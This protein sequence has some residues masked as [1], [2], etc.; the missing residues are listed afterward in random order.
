[1]KLWGILMKSK[2]LVNKSFVLLLIRPVSTINSRA[3][4]YRLGLNFVFTWKR[5][6][7]RRICSTFNESNFTHF[8]INYGMAL[9]VG[10]RLFARDLWGKKL[11]ADAKLKRGTSSK[12]RF[13]STLIKKLQQASRESI[14]RT[15]VVGNFLL[16]AN[17]EIKKS[18][19]FSALGDFQRRK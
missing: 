3:A 18:V 16:S 14:D 10:A 1:M 7:Q 17:T 19:I 13:Y 6:W 8:A 11:K 15:F 9:M 2:W 5:N 4:N 12:F